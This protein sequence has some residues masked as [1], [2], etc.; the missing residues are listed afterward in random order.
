MKFFKLAIMTP[1]TNVTISMIKNKHMT[2]FTIKITFLI[3]TKLV[4][5]VLVVNSSTHTRPLLFVVD[6]SFLMILFNTLVHG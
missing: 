2:W 4:F 6:L 3:L 1:I 5:L